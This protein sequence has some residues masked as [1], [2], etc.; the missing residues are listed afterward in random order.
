FDPESTESIRDALARGLSSSEF[1]E[2]VVLNQHTDF[3][4]DR[5][6]TLLRDAILNFTNRP[7]TRRRSRPRLAVVTPL[8]PQPSGIAYYA[9]RLL[10]E[11][12][13]HGSVTA[14]TSVNEEEGEVAFEPLP[15]C[16]VRE[17]Q[18]LEEMHFG[19]QPFDRV[20]YMMG[21]SRFHVLAL[22]ILRRLP[23][24]V[25]FHDAR[26][27]GLYNELYRLLPDQLG[28]DYVGRVLDQMYPGRYRPS[29][30]ESHT[31]DAETAGRFGILMAGEIMRCA[32]LRFCHS[33]HAARLL[34]LDSGSSVDHLF[35]LPVPELSA[36]S[37]VRESSVIGVFGIVDPAK[38]PDLVIEACSLLPEA[39][40]TVRFVGE[41]EPSLR[42]RLESQAAELDVEV[43]FTGLIG[44]E[45]FR[46]QQG[47]VTVAV[48]LRRLSNGESSGALAELI[49][50]ETPTITTDVGAVRE[51][52]DGV[53]APVPTN[54]TAQELAD[55][56]SGITSDPYVTLG[57]AESMRRYAG[58][59]GY[60]I[61]AEKLVERLG[62][63]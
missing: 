39:G 34:Q 44:P 49:A 52:P 54:L 6:A 50:A 10:P 53:V 62:L 26:L 38:N 57:M 5:S 28:A 7:N 59:N 33:D 42:D 3:T 36:D 35:D 13:H 23:G 58:G 61:A 21:N 18:E 22:S 41:C 56:I 30:V 14:F 31:I 20:V 32:T 55:Q 9:E 40:T 37:G 63:N 11:L 24:A 51:I 60:A 43:E 15:G 17:L 16:R 4:W 46:R 27:V 8:P 29:V 1:R 12:A 2:A 48:Q 47:A 25:V 45:E 19:G